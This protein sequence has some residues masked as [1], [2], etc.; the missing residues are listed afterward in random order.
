LQS[1]GQSHCHHHN[2]AHNVL[3]YFH[4]GNHLILFIYRLKINPDFDLLFML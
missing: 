4:D 1:Y 2:L 3:I